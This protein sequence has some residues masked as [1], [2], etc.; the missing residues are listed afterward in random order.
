MANYTVVDASWQVQLV[1]GGPMTTISGTI[2]QVKAQLAISNPGW[3]F[4]EPGAAAAAAYPV[5]FK[6]AWHWCGKGHKDSNG[7]EHRPA[8]YGRISDGVEYLRGTGGAG[9]AAGSCARISCS[10]ESAAS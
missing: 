7:Y 8:F 2:Q 5:R 6:E 9:V 3:K 4:G 10:Y 1:P